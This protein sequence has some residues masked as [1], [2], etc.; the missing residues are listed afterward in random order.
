M[1]KSPLTREKSK[2]LE[3]S[4]K[5]KKDTFGNFHYTSGVQHLAEKNRCYWLIDLISSF[6]VVEKIE[7]EE[8]QVYTITRGEDARLLIEISDGNDNIIYKKEIRKC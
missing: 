8:F 7:K 3:R 1:K 2:K 6:Q 4:C 5:N